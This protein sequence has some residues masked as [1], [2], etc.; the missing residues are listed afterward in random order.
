MRFY[1]IKFIGLLYLSF[2]LLP[3]A[4]AQNVEALKKQLILSK[5]DSISYHLLYTLGEKY[6][7]I[8]ADSSINYLN[9][10]LKIAQKTKNQFNI[11]KSIC[12]LGYM[13]LYY[14][15]DETKALAYYNNAIEIAKKNNDYESLAK[16]YQRLAIISQHQN[17]ANTYELMEK[18]LEYAEK[19]KKWKI[20]ADT[21]DILSDY[22]LKRKKYNKAAFFALSSLNTSKKH[23]L[24]IWF[25]SGLDYYELLKLQNKESEALV[26][27]KE[28]ERNKNK[29]KKSKGEFIYLNDVGK[30]ET[31]LKNYDE[32]EKLFLKSLDIEKSKAKVDTFHLFFIFQNLEN[33]Y[34]QKGDFKKAHH[35]SK[36]LVEVMLWLQQKRQTKDIK[37]QMTKLKANI[38]IEKKEAE[39]SLLE[40]NQKQQKYFLIG[41]VLFSILL[42]SF[43]IFLQK[44]NIKIEQQR[45]E[46]GQL[47][48][49]KDKIF[50]I[51]SHDLRSPVAALKNYMMLLNW[52]AL[53]QIEFADAA[54]SLNSQLN[55]VHTMVENVLNWSISQMGGMKP[56]MILTEV[57]IVI[58]EQIQ[59]LQTVLSVKN[60]EIKNNIPLDFQLLIDK[61][62]LEI[63]IR[64]LLQNAVKFTENSGIIEV[65]LSENSDFCKLGITDN[66]VG[67]AQEK[68]PQLFQ[69]SK[70][71]SS[72][73]TNNE[74][75]TGLGL[76]L[77][78]ELVE[79]NNGKISVRSKI[80]IGTTFTISWNKT[81]SGSI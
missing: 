75:G 41:A 70:S 8:D 62:H 23:N 37:L 78:K 66:G 33:L 51:L 45:I 36:E 5:T 9:Q 49:T 80:G 22:F 31:I 13:Y 69:L 14:I 56:N 60:I 52:G 24:D 59:L 39:I 48:S 73:G 28:L 20:L 68:L 79:L 6:E 4:K 58:Q 27:A 16:A 46:L 42:I 38:D 50:A 29:L 35:S 72:V 54:K 3:S 19:S 15:K 7:Y 64:N 65:N 32:A 57:N 61:N 34:L 11:A 21:K 67:I 76:N 17:I 1:P 77:V 30:L 2:F 12:Q 26:F 44:N 74:Q 63:I 40:N 18:S 47:N 10:A 53:N 43:L 71:I 55:N 81:N 25:T